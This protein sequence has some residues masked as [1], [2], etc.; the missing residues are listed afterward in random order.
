MTG[1]MA[2]T[3]LSPT[4]SARFGREERSEIGVGIGPVPMMKFLCR[5]TKEYGVKTVVSLNS[6]MVDA[7]GMCGGLQSDGGGKTRFCCV[8]GPEFDGTRSTTMNWSAATGLHDG[9]ET[10]HGSFHGTGEIKGDR[11]AEKKEKIPKQKMPEQAPEVR[12]RNFN[13][14]PF[15]YP[16]ELALLESSRCLQCKKPKCVEGCPVEIDIPAFVKLIREGDYAGAARK[17]K[18][19]NSLPA[20]CGRVCPRRISARSYASLGRRTTRSPLAARTVCRRL[21]EG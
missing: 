7:T 11:H 4:C 14:V 9:R 2:T 21:G 15:G 8:D 17:L 10:F 20:V 6:I 18:E 1:V 16:P 12:A 13:E 5:L 19:R 3:V